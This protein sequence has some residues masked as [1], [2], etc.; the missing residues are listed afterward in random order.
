MPIWQPR[1]GEG[2]MWGVVDTGRRRRVLVADGRRWGRAGGTARVG[3]ADSVDRQRGTVL[4]LRG[5][6]SAPA[7]DQLGTVQCRANAAACGGAPV[8]VS[9]QELQLR[10]RDV[11]VYYWHLMRQGETY[12]PDT[13]RVVGVRW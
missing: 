4:L 13:V 9:L 3:R 1:D 7:R 6:W 12:V 5:G 11:A 8:H 2:A 10:S